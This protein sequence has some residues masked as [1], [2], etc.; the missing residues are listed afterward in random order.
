MPLLLCMGDLGVKFQNSNLPLPKKELM[1][2][3]VNILWRCVE[4][5][6]NSETVTDTFCDLIGL[7]LPLVGCD[8]AYCTIGQNA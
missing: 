4:Y 6:C 7:Y 5:V 8:L 1:W 2:M 3:G